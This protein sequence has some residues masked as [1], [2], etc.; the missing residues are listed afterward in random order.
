MMIFPF[1]VPGGAYDK[2]YAPPFF[3]FHNL[4]ISTNLSVWLWKR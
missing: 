1:N 3:V 2:K 4:Y